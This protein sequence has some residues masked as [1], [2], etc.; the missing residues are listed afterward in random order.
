MLTNDERMMSVGYLSQVGAG[1]RASSGGDISLTSRG[2]FTSAM[3]RLS[4]LYSAPSPQAPGAEAQRT[5]GSVSAA[6]QNRLCA[7]NT[8][9]RVS[10]VSLFVCVLMR[11]LGKAA[12]SA[13]RPYFLS[14]EAG[15]RMTADG[16]RSWPNK[17][18]RTLLPP[19]TVCLTVHVR[20]A[21]QP[22][23]RSRD[24]GHASSCVRLRQSQSST[25]YSSLKVARRAR[26]NQLLLSVIRGTFCPL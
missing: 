2:S 22:Q 25:C 3:P 23:P 16:S 17:M 13:S 14:V 15:K 8:R 18:S 24:A 19:R 6:V 4:G 9:H 5:Q 26:C 20:N 12:G 7:A 1:G 21:A 10:T 11:R